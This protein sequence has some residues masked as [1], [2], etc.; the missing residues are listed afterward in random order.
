V[1]VG[2]VFCF[3][4]F[5]RFTW[6][7]M[8]RITK[9]DRWEGKHNGFHHILFAITDGRHAVCLCSTEPSVPSFVDVEV[10]LRRMNCSLLDAVAC[11]RCF[12]LSINSAAMTDNQTSTAD[13]MFHHAIVTPLVKPPFLLAGSRDVLASDA[14][15]T[16]PPDDNNQNTSAIIIIVL[17]VVVLAAI[18]FTVCG[19]LVKSQALVKAGSSA[20]RIRGRFHSTL[21][22]SIDL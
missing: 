20:T 7:S 12:S 14:D 13:S 22:S 5:N 18:F 9:N 21:S 17:S 15:Y 19:L 3:N 6:F 16:A 2:N 10:F 1:F 4:G 8:G 11:C